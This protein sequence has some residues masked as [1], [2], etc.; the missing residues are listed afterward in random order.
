LQNT[1]PSD[2]VV[3]IDASRNRSGGAIRHLVGILGSGDP[4]AHGVKE[5]HVWSYDALLRAL[6]NANWLVKHSPKDLKGSLLR[7][8]WWQR[9]SLANEARVHG[10]DIV[11]NTDAGTIS[12]VHPAV[13]MSR[14]MTQYEPGEMRRYRKLS[15]SWL[16]NA[17]LRHVQAWS[18]R[19]ADG[20]IFLTQYAAKVIQR[21]TGPLPRVAVIPHGVGSGFRRARTSVGFVGRGRPAQCLYVSQ[22][23]VYKHQWHVVRAVADL[24]RRGHDVV[25]VLAGGGAGP[26]QKRLDEEIARSDP[27]GAFVKQVGAVAPDR[28]P[29]LLADS[30]IFVFA[31]SCENMPNTLVEGM[32]AGLPIASSDRGPMPE[33]LRDGG[34]YFDPEDP[35]SIASAIETL[36]VDHQIRTQLAKRAMELSREYSWERCAME[37]WAFLRETLAAVG[38]RPSTSAP[39]ASRT[40][41]RTWM[42]ERT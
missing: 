12:R 29:T 27:A 10:V 34:T 20:V 1:A 19:D 14:D 18:L 5:V 15:W 37:T 24:R 9:R 30:D 39:Q 33:V 11:L 35:V 41:A 32:A 8:A 7:Q 6:P 42:A 2:I 31:S 4:R 22:A 36:L 23:D 38:G 17:A 25:L 40:M 26:A 3:G 21:S 28:L 13:T 16:R